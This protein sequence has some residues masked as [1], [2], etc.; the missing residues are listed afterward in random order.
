MNLLWLESAIATST[1]VA[2]I[3]HDGRKLYEDAL[4]NLSRLHILL[5]STVKLALN[6]TFKTSMRQALTGGGASGSFGVFAEKDDKQSR[7]D[8]EILDSFALERWETILHYLVS[9]G[10]GQN[11]TKP[12]QGVLFLLQRSGLMGSF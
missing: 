4:A 7:P 9:S 10:T 11:P 2:W 1:M 12:S 6:F 8:L 5:N 3:Q